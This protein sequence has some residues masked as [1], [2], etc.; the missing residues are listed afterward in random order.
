MTGVCGRFLHERLA[1]RHLTS[2]RAR[3]V[4]LIASLVA[5]VDITLQFPR[6]W[7]QIVYTTP[8]LHH[9]FRDHPPLTDLPTEICIGTLA[10]K[11]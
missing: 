9:P 4:L 11:I 8:Q 3:P 2:Q 5:T 1:K 6:L 7:N 10:A